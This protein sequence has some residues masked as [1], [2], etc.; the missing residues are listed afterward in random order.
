M[1]LDW[2]TDVRSLQYFITLTY[3]KLRQNDVAE[4][5]SLIKFLRIKPLNDW[6]TF[7]EKIAQPVKTG[8]GA[9]TAMK[10]LQVVLKKIMLRRRKDDQ[11]NGKALI[12]LPKRT[13]EITSCDFDAS[14]RAFYNALETKM[15]SVVE[16]LMKQSGKTGGSSYISVLLLLLRLRQACNHPL[17]VSEDYKK[18]SDALEPKAVEKGKDDQAPDADD[19]LAAA[20]GQ[21]GVTKKCKM[22]TVE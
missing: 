10:R 2:H 21:M 17:L 19:D 14:E 3:I 20:F 22:C 9:S 8:R 11:L 5:Y 12:Q 4:L 13:V 18:D 15:E 1:V 7:N 16:K 6:P